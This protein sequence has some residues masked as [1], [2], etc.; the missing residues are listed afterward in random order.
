MNQQQPLDGLKFIESVHCAEFN[1]DGLMIQK[2]EYLN[3]LKAPVY[4][5]ELKKETL[6]HRGLGAILNDITKNHEEEKKL[7]EE[8]KAL[9]GK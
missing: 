1:K 2:E 9:F 5:P 4:D 8:L 7:I 3:K 6:K